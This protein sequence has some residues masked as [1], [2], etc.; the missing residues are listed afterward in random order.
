MTQTDPTFQRVDG[1]P[2]DSAPSA[3]KRTWVR[4][5]VMVIGI[6][7]LV[8]GAGYIAYQIFK[9]HI[10]H[11]TVMQAPS[12]APDMDGLVF[13]DGTPVDI[14]DFRGD[15]VL[16]YFGYTHCPDVCPTTLNK[17]ARALEQVGADD[18]VHVMMVSVDPERDD[19]ESL[20]EYVTSFGDDF[21]GATGE[22]SDIERV[23][24]EYGVFF[25]RGDDTA[26][27]YDVD[28]TASLLGIDTD[29]RLRLVWPTA[30]SV[31]DLAADVNELL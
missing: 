21:L 4:I 20:G 7:L 19:L 17:A 28:H 23:A 24:T 30:V 12:R 3:P 15:V 18:R 31:D 14:A 16:I 13:A 29:G 26:T 22:L 10:Y 1:A 9:P 11:G 27:G 2:S 6:P 8:V 25:A 5:V